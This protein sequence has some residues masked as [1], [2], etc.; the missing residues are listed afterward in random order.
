MPHIILVPTSHVALESVKKIER[1][2]RKEK[3]D[4]VA[5][6]LDAG[7]YLGMKMGGGLPPVRE[8]GV[9]SYIVFFVMKKIQS[10]IGKKAGIFPGSEMLKAV[11][12]GRGEGADVIFIDRD[13]RETFMR[14]KDISWREKVKLVLLLITGLVG[15]GSKKVDL[16]KVPGDTIINEAMGFLEKELPGFYRVLVEER[17]HFMAHQL[18]RLGQR[19][20]KIVAVIGAGH[21]QGILALL[22]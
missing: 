18:V 15:F 14:I 6:E 5:V 7:R 21:K 16:S 11:E 2:I 22:K 20:N 1:T 19:Y 12:V 10:W 13:I 3:P 9:G 17:N 8:V 4:C